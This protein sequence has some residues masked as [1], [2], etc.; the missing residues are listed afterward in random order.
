MHIYIYIYIYWSS[1]TI[2]V[3]VQSCKVGSECKL[4][5]WTDSSVG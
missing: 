4:N 1:C 2:G 5:S 3:D